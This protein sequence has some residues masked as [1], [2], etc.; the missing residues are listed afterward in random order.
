MAAR[1]VPE[2]NVICCHPLL[3]ASRNVSTITGPVK[4]RRTEEMSL[5]QDLFSHPIFG[6]LIADSQRCP[7]GPTS[8]T[9]KMRCRGRLPPQLIVCLFMQRQAGWLSDHIRHTAASIK[10]TSAN[11][12]T[13]AK[14][15]ITAATN[16]ATMVMRRWDRSST[17]YH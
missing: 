7:V 13:R 4:S 12:V 15:R 2:D 1:R 9:R 16:N 6:H 17:A 11:G 8:S 14:N 10:C 3:P 5:V